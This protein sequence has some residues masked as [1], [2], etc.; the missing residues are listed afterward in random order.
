VEGTDYFEFDVTFNNPVP[1][2][3]MDEFDDMFV[4]TMTKQLQR[5]I[6]VKEG[7]PDHAAT[8]T[9]IVWKVGL[10]SD[11]TLKYYPIY[12]RYISGTVTL[13]KTVQAS[14]TNGKDNANRGKRFRMSDVS[15]YEIPSYVEKVYEY[16]CKLVIVLGGTLYPTANPQLATNVIVLSY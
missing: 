9:I 2:K 6:Y 5:H 12:D 1:I 11:L 13:D 4:L 14:F 10:P 15:G 3:H 8:T 7:F 16:N